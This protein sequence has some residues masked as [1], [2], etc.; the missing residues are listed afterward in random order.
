MNKKLLA[1]LA[2]ALALAMIFTLCP[3]PPIRVSAATRA[4]AV[5]EGYN[6]HDYN[7]CVDF[8]EQAPNGTKNGTILF[9]GY[10]PTD[11]TTWSQVSMV[12]VNGFQWT[13]E[14]GEKRLVKIT[15][16]W[17]DRVSG[18]CDFSGCSLLKRVYMEGVNIEVFD[19]SDC[20]SLTDINI[21]R[22][23]A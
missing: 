17:A 12:W 23:V 6:A 11:P 2:G 15:T 19:F 9:A 16:S 14:N 10:D 5:P 4:Y 3:I 8:L 1:V 21:E 18:E 7:K 22:G 20:S 13:E